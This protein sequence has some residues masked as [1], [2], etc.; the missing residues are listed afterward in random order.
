[1]FG[2]AYKFYL[3]AS[4]PVTADITV[5]RTFHYIE[6][7]VCDNILVYE[8]DEEVSATIKKGQT[9]SDAGWINTPGDGCTNTTIDPKGEPEM[10]WNGQTINGAVYTADGTWW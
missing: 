1:M 4:E 2:N 6:M 10:K 7:N 3:I 9:E 8:N 5:K